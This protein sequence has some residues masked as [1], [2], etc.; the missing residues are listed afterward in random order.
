MHIRK[1]IFF[2]SPHF[3]FLAAPRPVEHLGQRSDLN[4]SCSNM[5]S[6]T[7]CASQGLNL[8]LSAPKTP[9]I[10][11]HHSRNSCTLEILMLITKLS[12]RKTT[13]LYSCWS[14]YE[15][16]G[17]LIVAHQAMNLT[18]THE[19][20]GSIP[21]LSCRLQTQPGSHVATAVAYIGWQLL[22]SDFH[23]LQVQP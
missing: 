1:K 12:S 13:N 2:F 18:S 14:E 7:H 19:D 11:L 16:V 4:C 8:C 23:M 15:N 6:L 22:I 17:V 5:G 9:P 3:S 20:A 21:G 10:L